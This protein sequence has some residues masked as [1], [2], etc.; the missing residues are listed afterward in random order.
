MAKENTVSDTITRVNLGDREIIIIGTAH[1]SE[2]SVD[3]VKQVL[4]EE[5]PDRVCVELDEGRYKSITS[6]KKWDNLDIFQVLKQKKGFLLLANLV[7]SS[8]QKRLGA[9][10]VSK[11]GEE[12]LAAVKVAQELDIPFSLIDRE[13]QVTLRRAWAKSGFLG[14]NKLLAALLSSVLF[15]EKVSKEDIEELKKKS[16]LQSMMD[17]LAGYLPRVKE[18]LI[19]ERDQFLAT[20]IFQTTEKKVVAV[21]GAG[22]V[23]GMVKWLN[24]LYEGSKKDNLEDISKVP[25]PGI[26]AKIIPWLIPA[27]V[28]GLIVT[29]FI[30]KGSDV[31]L[32]GITHWVLINGIPS[33]IGALLAL[34]HPLT[35][36]ISFLA[37]PFTS[38]VPVIG[39]GFVA[40]FIEALLRKPKVHDFEHLQEDITSLG[41]FFKNRFT[42]VLIVMVLS[43]LGSTIGTISGFPQLISNLF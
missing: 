33:A 32:A 42:H 6:D 22:H 9:D 18:V 15:D 30:M 36:V 35:I 4:T 43:S 24:D 17:E 5:K 14:K 37:A 25:S 39:V 8:F 11:P 34:A 2:E 40:A 31:G 10:S 1:V 41:G 13:V 26:V 38:L 12:M 28:I 23:P 19:D 7:L 16:A 29:A 3:E 21:V 27:A 20:K